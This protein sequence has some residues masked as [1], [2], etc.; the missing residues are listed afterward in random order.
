MSYGN[1]SVAEADIIVLER[2]VQVMEKE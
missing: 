2:V 1:T